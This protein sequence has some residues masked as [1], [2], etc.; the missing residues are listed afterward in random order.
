[1]RGT[2]SELFGVAK[3]FTLNLPALGNIPTLKGLF[4]YLC[5]CPEVKYTIKYKPVVGME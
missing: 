4:G 3:G 5:K 1:M 2:N